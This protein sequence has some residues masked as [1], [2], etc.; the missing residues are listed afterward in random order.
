MRLLFFELGLRCFALT[1]PYRIL[2][3]PALPCSTLRCRIDDVGLL[4]VFFGGPFSAANNSLNY[5]FYLFI[6]FLDDFL[7]DVGLNNKQ[8][9]RPWF[10]VRPQGTLQQTIR[11]S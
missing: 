6:L 7:G 4:S 3:C 5:V 10:S 1:S 11:S 2:P 9:H 8:V